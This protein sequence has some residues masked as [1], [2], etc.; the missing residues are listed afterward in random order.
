[1]ANPHTSVKARKHGVPN[2]MSSARVERVLREGKR[3]PPE[4]LLLVR[5]SAPW[6]T[7]AGC[8]RVS[9]GAGPIRPT[10]GASSRSRSSPGRRHRCMRHVRSC[11]PV[12]H[13]S[14]AATLASA[15]PSRPGTSS[16][17]SPTSSTPWS[18]I[19]G[20]ADHEFDVTLSRHGKDVVEGAE[21]VDQRVLGGKQTYVRIRLFHYPEHRFG[22]VHNADAEI[23]R[24]AAAHCTE[25]SS[26]R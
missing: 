21:M 4:N 11:G 15:S 3:L 12:P 16:K 18:R 23:G 24:A 13:A 22:R 19:Q 5:I 8:D 20:R 25:T 1:M 6:I 7:R 26:E 17:R 2:K 10:A 9:L 14:A